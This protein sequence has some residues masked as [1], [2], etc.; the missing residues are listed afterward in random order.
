MNATATLSS[1][2]GAASAIRTNRFTGAERDALL[3]LAFLHLEQARPADAAALL[4]PLHRV[5]PDDHEV[6]RCLALAEL[7]AGEPAAAARLAARAYTRAPASLQSILGLVY[8]KALWQLNDAASARRVL[9]E[10][11]NTGGDAS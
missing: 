8:A 4:R 6:E 2:N 5:Q 1:A 7:S 3:V 9:L 10:L 11:V